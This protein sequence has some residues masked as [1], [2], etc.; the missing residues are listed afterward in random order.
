MS[1]T[2]DV[3][4]NRN[5]IEKELRKRKQ[6]E[7]AQ[8]RRNTSF[9]AST[10]EFLKKLDKLLDSEEVVSV[11]IRISEQDIA[12]FG[13]MLIESHDLDAYTI[14]QVRGKSNEF[15]ISKKYIEL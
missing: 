6:Q 15:E 1:R 8:L 13:S 3:I 14:K 2:L 7:I 12:Q 11:T 9:R 4:R 5:K 10:L